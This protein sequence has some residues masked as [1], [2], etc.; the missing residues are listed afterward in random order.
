MTFFFGGGGNRRTEFKDPFI[1][2]L[3][4]HHIA[5]SHLMSGTL[6]HWG[7]VCSAP[8]PLQNDGVVCSVN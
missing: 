1:Q 2:V 7:K 5:H 8:H 4:S 6:P 3:P